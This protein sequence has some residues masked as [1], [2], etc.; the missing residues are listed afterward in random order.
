MVDEMQF[1]GA[2]PSDSA[3]SGVSRSLDEWDCGDG[4]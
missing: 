2:F 3:I 4:S 1:Q